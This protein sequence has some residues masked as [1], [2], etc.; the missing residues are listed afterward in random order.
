MPFPQAGFGVVGGH[1]RD[2]LDIWPKEV[3]Q[4]VQVGGGG[5]AWRTWLARGSLSS[6]SRSGLSGACRTNTSSTPSHM[7]SQLC[8]RR[9]NLWQGGNLPNSRICGWGVSRDTL[10]WMFRTR[11]LFFLLWGKTPYSQNK[12]PWVKYLTVSDCEALV[13]EI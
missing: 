6:Q 5:G 8:V 13:L 4:R 1:V 2:V 7:H 12:M 11:W 10:F 9:L 3:V